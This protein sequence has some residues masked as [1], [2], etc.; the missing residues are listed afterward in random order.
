MEYGSP[1]GPGHDAS[2]AD[3]H[4]NV[5][6]FLEPPPLVNLTLESLDFPDYYT[7]D[8]DIGLRHPFEEPLF[9]GFD[10]VRG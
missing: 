7:I 2:T 9:T 5:Q 10:D 1:H 3:W 6:P 4:L 8:A